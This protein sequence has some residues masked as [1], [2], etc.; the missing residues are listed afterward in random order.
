MKKWE[1]SIDNVVAREG[2]DG[3]DMLP[4]SPDSAMRAPNRLGQS[5][6]SGR[7]HEQE[8][9]ARRRESNIGYPSF[10]RRLE[11]GAVFFSIDDQNPL[12]IDSVGRIVKQAEKIRGRDKELAVAVIDQLREL[13]ASIG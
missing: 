6:R 8:E 5:C 10:V 11:E 3:S 1:R 4:C 13:C 12:G 7:K 2:G 9:I